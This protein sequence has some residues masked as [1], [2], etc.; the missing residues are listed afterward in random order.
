MIITRAG[1]LRP[2]MLSQCHVAPHL[3]FTFFDQVHTTGM[4]IKQALSCTAAVTLGKIS[5]WIHTY[6]L[7]T[8]VNRLAIRAILHNCAYRV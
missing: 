2:M 8:I 7:H 1:G 3:R 4:D 6:V 5:P